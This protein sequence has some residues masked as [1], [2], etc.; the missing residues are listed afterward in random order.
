MPAPWRPP[1][2]PCPL[3]P[4]S[5]AAQPPTRADLWPQ[6]FSDVNCIALWISS[7]KILTK[8]YSVLHWFHK[9]LEVHVKNPRENRCFQTIIVCSFCSV[10]NSNKCAVLWKM[11]VRLISVSTSV[12]KEM[13]LMLRALS[14]ARAE[15]PSQTASHP[16]LGQI[17]S[18][19]TSE[20][21]V[22][23]R[24]LGI[25]SRLG[26]VVLARRTLRGVGF[27]LDQLQRPPLTALRSDV[28]PDG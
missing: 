22:S 1:R 16:G 7:E 10:D 21:K 23:A 6:L 14:R 25:D 3:T 2:R 18:T 5:L 12:N 13:C 19:L 8:L 4:P 20:D 28:F 26:Q 24:N 15:L 17:V 27:S 11:A 9:R